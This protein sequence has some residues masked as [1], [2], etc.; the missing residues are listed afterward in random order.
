MENNSKFG[1]SQPALIYGGLLGIFTIIHSVIITLAGATY[2]AYNQVSA[3]LI[4][5]IGLLFCLY[6]YRKEYL[7]NQM[8]YGQAFLMGLGII[9]ISGLISMVYTYI[10]ISF[11]HPD[12][13]KEAAVIAEEKLLERGIDAG[14]IETI[15]ERTARLRTVKWLLISS[16]IFTVVYGAIVSLIAAAIMKKEPA[17]PF[18]NIA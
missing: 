2:S 3:Y 7:N 12:F 10:Y 9:I 8:T 17:E 11:I 13:F 6:A 4:P 1:F 15:M 5:L 14:M 18:A 16:L